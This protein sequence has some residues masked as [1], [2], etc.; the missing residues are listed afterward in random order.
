MQARSDQDRAHSPG[1]GP[2]WTRTGGV[3][4]VVAADNRAHAATAGPSA[5]SVGVVVWLASE[6]MFFAGLF[7]AWFSLRSANP[8]WPPAGVELATARTTGATVVL[9]VSSFTMHGAVKAAERDDRVS[10]IRWLVLTAALAAVFL[11]NLGF[12]Y[13]ELSFSISTHAYGSIFY[14]MTGFH[15]LHVVGG[16]LFMLGVSATIAGS[17]S[18]APAGPTIEVCAYYW[19]FV[20]VVWVAMFATIYLLG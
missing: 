15:G 17:S 16:I 13:H 14:L 18:K 20:D 7:A 10:A 1:V 12:E 11:T 6:M 5:L 3:S 19:H 8:V 4:D 9:I 2:G